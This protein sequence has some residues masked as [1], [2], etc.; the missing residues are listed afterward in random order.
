MA[1]K[2]TTEIILN[3][4]GNLAAKAR[5]YGTS[6]S[7]F[8]QRNEKSMALIRRSTLAAGRGIDRLGNR[9]VGLAST[10]ATGLVLKN[11][12]DVDRQLSRLAIAADISRKKTQGL[13]DEL[14]K[15]AN[16][17]KVDPKQS[18][19]A[20]NEIM[21]KIGDLDY[22]MANKRVIPMVIQATGASGQEVGGVLTDLKKLGITTKEQVMAAIDTLNV[23]GKSGAFT[24]SGLAPVAPQVLSTYAATGRTGLDAV[25]EL[26][27]VLQVIRNS[28]GSNAE[29]VTRFEAIVRDLQRP[30]TVK[31][32]KNEAGIDVYNQEL[33]KQGKEVMRPLPNILREIVERSK[34]TIGG[35]SQTEKLADLNLSDEGRQALNGL[36]TDF[37][38]TGKVTAFQKFMAVTGDGTQT[39]KDAKVAASDFAASM[40]SLT[41]SFNRFA[42]NQ[43]TGPI[44]DIADAINSVDDATVQH[45]LKWGEVAAGAVG[46][47]ILATKGLRAITKITNF[48]RELLSK[49]NTKMGGVKNAM[50][51]LGATPVYVVN[52]PGSGMGATEGGIDTTHKKPNKRSGKTTTRSSKTGRTVRRAVSIGGTVG[53]LTWL[54][55]SER[56]R[57]YYKRDAINFSWPSWLGSRDQSVSNEETDRSKMI[58]QASIARQQTVKT[59]QAAM[60]QPAQWAAPSPF[61]PSFHQNAAQ[62]TPAMDGKLHVQVDV[63]DRRV[64]THVT[65]ATPSITVDPDAG[66]N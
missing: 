27:A 13:W 26:G 36:L 25:R 49:N 18:L 37:K 31:T 10:V 32:L 29:A 54:S 20:I 8:A 22:A 16:E 11:F 3:L 12:E 35:R 21:T 34:T 41:N 17:F 15:S 28:S 44:Q 61:I 56:V 64:R 9:Y 58:N 52:M 23:Q 55:N 19:A 63:D 33:L 43:L 30:Q 4:S 42:N 7:E 47:V 59:I 45:W 65:S 1:Q 62:P 38:N 57:K 40:Q 60:N 6:M 51:S 46:G 50:S 5:R 48:G 53:L 2:L 14:Q 24:L 39:M 66:Q